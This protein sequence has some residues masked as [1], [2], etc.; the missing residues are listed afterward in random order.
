MKHQISK[1]A[2][3]DL[4]SL[5]TQVGLNPDGSTYAE[6][7]LKMHKGCNIKPLFCKQSEP[8]KNRAIEIKA[9]F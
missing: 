5:F 1:A 9:E 3:Y 7:H 4:Q 6:G 2:L 8:W